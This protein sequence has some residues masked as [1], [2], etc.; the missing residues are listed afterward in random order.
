[1]NISD[2]GVRKGFYITNA[3]ALHILKRQIKMSTLNLRRLLGKKK[4]KMKANPKLGK[5]I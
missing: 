1:M 4:L 5:D 3:K 2:T